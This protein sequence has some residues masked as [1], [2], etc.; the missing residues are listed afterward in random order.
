ML[1]KERRS[2][3]DGLGVGRFIEGSAAKLTA[4]RVLIC[5]KASSVVASLTGMLSWAWDLRASDYTVSEGVPNDPPGRLLKSTARKEVMR[6]L[7]QQSTRY[8]LHKA[9]LFHL[10]FKRT[11]RLVPPSLMFLAS[12]YKWTFSEGVSSAEFILTL[13]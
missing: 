4:R 11:T 5:S 2:L 8:N 6:S 12:Y 3:P 7:L 13:L 10:L 1:S 9:R